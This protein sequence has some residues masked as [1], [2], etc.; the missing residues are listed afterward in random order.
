[1]SDGDRQIGNFLLWMIVASVKLVV[2]PDP[3]SQIIRTEAV[4]AHA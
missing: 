1:M 3:S 4:S 2:R